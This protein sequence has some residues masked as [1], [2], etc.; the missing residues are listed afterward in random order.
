MNLTLTIPESTQPPI[1]VEVGGTTE[2]TSYVAQ[3]AGLPDYPA[4]FPPAIGSAANQAVAGNDPRLTNERAPSPHTHPLADLTGVTPAAIGAMANTPAAVAALSYTDAE[5]AS[6]REGIQ[7]YA[8]YSAPYVR[9]THDGATGANQVT[10]HGPVGGTGATSYV[11]WFRRSTTGDSRIF[12]GEYVSAGNQR[13]LA[14]DTYQGKMRVLYS[15]TGAALPTV[16][17]VGVPFS[18][19]EWF[20]VAVV[21]EPSVRLT[22]YVDG[23]VVAEKTSS[24]PAT[25]F[26]STAKFGLG[27]ALAGTA[28]GTTDAK[29]VMVFA[30][31]L[32]TA[33]VGEIFR[34]GRLAG[35]AGS[36]SLILDM[37]I[38]RKSLVAEDM[39]GHGNHL[40]IVENAYSV[41]VS[42]GEIPPWYEPETQADAEPQGTY[43]VS[44]NETD[45]AA[46]EAAAPAGYITKTQVGTTPVGSLAIN[47]YVFSPPGP[48]TVCFIG[49]GIH[50]MEVVSAQG[51]SRFFSDVV[52]R[53]TESPALEYARWK[54]KWIVMPNISP[55]G[56]GN[57]TNLLGGRLIPE[58]APIPVTWTRS[59]AVATI[60]WPTTVGGGF[61]DTGG[62]LNPVRYINGADVIGKLDVYIASSTDETALPNSTTSWSSG[63]SVL[64]TPTDYSITVACLNAGA[65]SGT[66]EMTVMAD[67]NRNFDTASWPAYDSNS[68]GFPQNKGSKPFSTAEALAVKTVIDAHAGE[69]MSVVSLHTG[70][71]TEDQSAHFYVTP[72]VRRDIGERIGQQVAS[73]DPGGVTPL[74]TLITSPLLEG[75]AAEEHLIQACTAE[76]TNVVDEMT[77]TL[78]WYGNMAINYAA[79]CQ[80][81]M[82]TR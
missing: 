48:E 77:N 66:A 45:W 56:T 31:A 65:T 16:D 11:G 3:V 1:T 18:V 20:H 4:T 58:T 70:Y 32:T 14:V 74:T 13:K 61:P 47:K 60:T 73:F 8:D 43:D 36:D 25:L 40:R 72:T 33:E 29:D 54:V 19:D 34:D 46:I 67:P 63:K 71:A 42:D 78:R 26:G 49:A 35:H 53:W 22:L 6:V 79:I 41:G 30:K 38:G 9:M 23:A 62:R 2:L 24:V 21:F 37:R 39:S 51:L 81:K 80:S 44:Q 7:I 68:Q 82:I 10:C 69:V 64:S 12:M 76:W 5:A 15:N 75:W 57:A 28:T 27:V 55:H 17:A 52:T 50:G 59:G